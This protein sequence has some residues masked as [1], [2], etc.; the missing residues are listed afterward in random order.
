MELLEKSKTPDNPLCQVKNCI[1]LSDG[2][3]SVEVTHSVEGIEQTV[4]DKKDVCI[5]HAKYIVGIAANG[6]SGKKKLRSYHRIEWKE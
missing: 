1:E 5:A 6:F 3:L 2:T 4:L